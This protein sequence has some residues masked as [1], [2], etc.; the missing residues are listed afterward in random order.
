[1]TRSE[2]SVAGLLRNGTRRRLWSGS[3]GAPPPAFP[4]VR[5]PGWATRV[6]RRGCWSRATG[7]E[8][9]ATSAPEDAP[10]PSEGRHTASAAFA[11]SSPTQHDTRSS[12]AG[13][14][15]ERNPNTPREPWRRWIRT[16]GLGYNLAMAR[17][18]DRDARRPWPGGPSGQ[19][20][21]VEPP[22]PEEGAFS[23]Q[24]TVSYTDN[25][26]RFGSKPE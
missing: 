10:P 20:S 5:K 23:R 15:R 25:S 7:K 18:S 9:K 17:T 26:S 19:I 12:D 24:I 8:H 2:F 1:V 6:G 4:E 11:G 16:S 21:P 14:G 22:P 3:C 13:Q